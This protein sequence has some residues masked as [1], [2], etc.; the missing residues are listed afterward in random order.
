MPWF[1]A[2][3]DCPESAHVSYLRDYDWGGPKPG[4]RLCYLPL[5]DGSIPYAIAPTPPEALAKQAQEQRENDRRLA[6]GEPLKITSNQPW[7]YSAPEYDGKVLA[8]TSKSASSLRITPE[9][10][11][12]LRASL[13]AIWW[14]GRRKAFNDAFPWVTGICAFLWA[15]TFA[16]GWLVRGFAGIPTGQDFK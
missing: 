9:L 2:P 16:M 4:L 5:E 15:F 13:Q 3:G 11:T 1:V 6:K 12:R 7:F 14:E 10:T 8:Y